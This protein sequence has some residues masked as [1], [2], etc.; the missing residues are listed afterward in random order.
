MHIL[1]IGGSGFIG[2]YICRELMKSNLHTFQV[3]D[4]NIPTINNI[5]F[6]QA[7]LL[8]IVDILLIKK[9]DVIINLAAEHADN[10]FPPELY[11]RTNVDGAKIVCA[12]ADFFDCKNILFTSSVAVY[13]THIPNA[14]ENSPTDPISD[15][16][17]SKLMAES[18]YHDWYLTDTSRT[19]NIIRPT[20]V[21]G[22]GNK[23]NFFNLIKQISNNRFLMIGN[24]SNRKSIAYVENLVSFIIFTI[25]YVKKYNMI[26]YVDKPDYKMIDLIRLIKEK[27]GLST[28]VIKIPYFLAIL[29]GASLD[30]ISR[31]SGVKFAIS[32]IRVKKFCTETTFSSK[33]I[34]NLDFVPPYTL[35]YGIFKT[36]ESDFS[37]L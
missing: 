21:F 7:D 18:I 35:D 27:L 25:L 28:N 3:L 17:R 12:L 24:G 19:L 10:V 37:Q 30:L 11:Y 2:G 29:I 23:G 4:K 16:G 14:N 36:I 22:P 26:V 5:G 1:I 13:G 34:K 8:N 6:V 31:F 32:K 20:V 9:P 15:Y 33:L